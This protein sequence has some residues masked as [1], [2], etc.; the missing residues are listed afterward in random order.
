MF[1]EFYDVSF[2]IPDKVDETMNG[3][4]SSHEN[5]NNSDHNHDKEDRGISYYAIDFNSDHD[6]DF[7]DFNP[8]LLLSLPELK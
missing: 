4:N 3:G 7:N 6:D 2:V 5:A 8:G 1:P